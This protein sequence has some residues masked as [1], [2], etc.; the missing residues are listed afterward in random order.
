M[1]VKRSSASIV[2]AGCALLALVA[3]GDDSS[4]STG[5]TLSG[6]KPGAPSGAGTPTSSTA[7]IPNDGTSVDDAI[8]ALRTA[9]GAVSEGR[10]FDLEREEEGTE[11]V[12]DTAVASGADEFQVLV[13]ADGE[14]VRSQRQVD[15]PSDDIAKLDSATVDAADA[16]RAAG[17]REPGAQFDEMEIDTDHSGV[18]VWQVELIR[19]D[20][21][22]V[23]YRVD[24]RTGEILGTGG[25]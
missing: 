25:G 19:D 14:N 16:L 5:G 12:F 9:A 15:N 1:R 24:A 21:I 20:G 7:A 17:E 23:T 18:V 11:S 8:A 3:C 2:V 22:D 6:T 4:D 10:P 13:D